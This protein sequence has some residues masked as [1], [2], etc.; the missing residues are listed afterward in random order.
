MGLLRAAELSK[1][2]GYDYF[3]LQDMNSWTT[4]SSYTSQGSSSTTTTGSATA[5]GYGNT[6]RAYGQSN[7]QTTYR[8]PQT[9]TYFKPNVAIVVQFLNEDE[10]K[11]LN[12]LSVDQV[13]NLYASKYGLA[14]DVD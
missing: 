7:S 11:A 9:T 2:N 10:A 4:S 13:Y 12:A 3:V 6:I 14:D 5:Y 8:P 1:M